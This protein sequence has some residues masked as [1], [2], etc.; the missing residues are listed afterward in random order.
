[1]SR[2]AAEA[3]LR[4]V[5]LPLLRGGEVQIGRPLG[6]AGAQR[7]V[8][9]AAEPAIA[10]QVSEV[11][12]A[13]A[14]RLLAMGI[15]SPPLPALTD[16]GDA[17]TGLVALHDLLFLARP[18]A[19]RL[20]PA[21][22]RGV[23]REVVACAERAALPL[24][25]EASEPAAADAVILHRHALIEPLFRLIRSDLRRKTWRDETLQRGLN[26]KSLASLSG[27]AAQVLHALP[28]T[29]LPLL[30]DGQGAAALQAVLGVSPLTALWSPRP[31]EVTQHQALALT[32]QQHAPLL[33]RPALAR[34]VCRRYLD[35]GVPAVAAALSGPL[36]AL[37]QQTVDDPARRPDAITWLCL[38]SHLHWLAYIALPATSLPELGVSDDS[39][40]WFGLFACLAQVAP[41]WAQPPDVIAVA[42]SSPSPADALTPAERALHERAQAHIR[43][44]RD[45]VPASQLASL[46]RLLTQALFTPAQ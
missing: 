42:G 29:E 46:H 32:L 17:L 38:V 23:L 21:T 37:L 6:W 33:R 13:C 27:D 30:V 15:L 11:R 43:R 31:V 12:A 20:S 9:A 2:A 26:R 45:S 36:L 35:L 24:A 8:A 10:A 1:M 39:A 3:F 25:A 16:D 22:R 4:D 44:C 40:P 7:I 19:Q 18:E 14:G 41:Q 5:V 28:W 34:I